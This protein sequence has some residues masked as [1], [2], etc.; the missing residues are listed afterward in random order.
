MAIQIY[1]WLWFEA[2]PRRL[3]RR[4][5]WFLLLAA[6]FLG[7]LAWLNVD[8]IRKGYRPTQTGFSIEPPGTANEMGYFMPETED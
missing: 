7:P 2:H 6:L 3:A 4:M 1:A 5:A 8:L